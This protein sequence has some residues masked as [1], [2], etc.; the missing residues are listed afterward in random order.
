MT[1][2][3]GTSA[4]GTGSSSRGDGC[5]GSYSYLD[6]FS[7]FN[8]YILD[9]AAVA[10]RGKSGVT[11]PGIDGS[12]ARGGGFRSGPLRRGYRHGSFPRKARRSPGAVV[13][14]TSFGRRQGAI[15]HDC[16][17]GGPRFGEPVSACRTGRRARVRSRRRRQRIRIRAR[18]RRRPVP[19]GTPERFASES[20][21]RGWSK[22]RK[23]ANTEISDHMVE[24]SANGVALPPGE[25]NGTEAFVYEAEF[26]PEPVV[27]GELQLEVKVP[28]RLRPESKDLFVDV[29]L[30]NWIEVDYP[31]STSFG[32]G[33]SAFWV[34]GEGVRSIGLDAADDGWLYFSPDQRRP[35]GR[36]KQRR[37]GRRSCW[38]AGHVRGGR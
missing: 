6:E 27:D 13:L 20:V 35:L 4:P 11:S 24:V 2:A 18:P 29:V 15:S 12:R 10:E 16:D 7:R 26:C 17:A 23:D 38:W 25:W 37:G 1:A 19:S 14:G 28:R 32:V 22:V 3:T 9:L 30:L 8:C 31:R 21:F 33:Q 34:E 36:G 5:S